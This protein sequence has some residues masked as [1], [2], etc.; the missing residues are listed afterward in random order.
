MGLINDPLTPPK[1][2][3]ILTIDLKQ[4]LQAGT[5][6]FDPTGADACDLDASLNA[7]CLNRTI[8]ASY[9]PLPES[10]GGVGAPDPSVEGFL[11]FTPSTE[12]YNYDAVPTK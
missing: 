4:Y 3:G 10:S 5:N 12:P 1:R 11:W 7:P 6:Y 2:V 8:T 9:T